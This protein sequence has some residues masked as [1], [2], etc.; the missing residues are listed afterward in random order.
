M[1][2]LPGIFCLCF[3]FKGHKVP[4]SVKASSTLAGGTSHTVPASL[5]IALPALNMECDLLRALKE[6]AERKREKH[7]GREGGGEGRGGRQSK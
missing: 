1:S 7:E 2:L 4:S 3:S 6:R 5:I